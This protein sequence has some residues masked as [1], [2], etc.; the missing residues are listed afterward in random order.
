M[1]RHNIFDTNNRFDP[2]FWNGSTPKGS[3]YDAV[4]DIWNHPDQYRLGCFRATSA[5]FGYGISQAIGR[6]KFNTL[7]GQGRLEEISLNKGLVRQQDHSPKDDWIP[8]DWGY[9]RNTG[10]THPPAGLEGENIVYLGNGKYWG[11][12]GGIKSLNQWINKVRS[13]NNASKLLSVRR[14]PAV[15]LN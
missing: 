9:V 6:H 11:F 1:N 13:W 2:S 3:P 4:H 7:W 8:G 12:P 10:T 15:G 14:Y 5:V